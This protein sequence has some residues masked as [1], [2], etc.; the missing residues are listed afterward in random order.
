[1]NKEKY[2]TLQVDDSMWDMLAEIH[3]EYGVNKSSL[4]RNVL[5][6][7]IK[8][9]KD[10]L[11][12]A[13]TEMEVKRKELLRQ[14]RELELAIKET[15]GQI[16][17]GDSILD[18]SHETSGI[19]EIVSSGHATGINQEGKQITFRS[20]VSLTQDLVNELPFANERVLHTNGRERVKEQWV[21]CADCA[22]LSVRQNAES[23]TY[24]TRAKNTK[25]QKSII[26]CA[27]GDTREITLEQAKK[28]HMQH[29]EDIYKKNIN[30]N[31]LKTE[32][33][34]TKTHVSEDDYRKLSEQNW[35]RYDFYRYDDLGLMGITLRG[36]HV[37]SM[38]NV[39]SNISNANKLL[40][41]QALD[42]W[43]QKVTDPRGDLTIQDLR[44]LQPFKDGSYISPI[45][46]LHRLCKYIWHYGTQEEKEL[47]FLEDK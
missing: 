21:H 13:T 4:V 12:G 15:K 3:K 29:M 32:K 23:N 22:G 41:S 7:H 47:L 11:V 38:E 33:N 44:R 36:T 16:D 24:Y 8:H 34:R 14:A 28:V 27:I 9:K 26:K 40:T 5:E 35:S 6:H 31:S 10:L 25:I 17:H 18:V 42:L 43:R 46:M 19:P 1:M 2:V 20:K 37:V 39:Q 45:G 30:P